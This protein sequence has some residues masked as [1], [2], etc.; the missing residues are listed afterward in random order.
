MAC[1][2]ILIL[3]NPDCMVPG[4]GGFIP[5]VQQGSPCFILQVYAA[6]YPW[7]MFP[8]FEGRPRRMSKRS[9]DA[10]GSPPAD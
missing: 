9:L 5:Y 7:H 8:G 3:N 2:I 6:T 1:K 10:R 4:I